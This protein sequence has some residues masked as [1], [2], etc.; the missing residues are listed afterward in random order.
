MKWSVDGE[1]WADNEEM[2]NEAMLWEKIEGEQLAAIHEW[3]DSRPAVFA[4]S[5]GKMTLQAPRWT[6]RTRYTQAEQREEWGSVVF[7]VKVILI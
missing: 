7:E 5:T 3:E 6:K 1:G 4:E 2:E